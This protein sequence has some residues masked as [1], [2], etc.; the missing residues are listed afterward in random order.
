LAGPADGQHCNNSQQHTATKPP[1]G[2]STT[3]G[4]LRTYDE[5]ARCGVPMKRARKASGP[6]C[7]VHTYSREA[8]R[9][10]RGRTGPWRAAPRRP[11]TRR[12]RAAEGR[13]FRGHFLLLC[14]G[15]HH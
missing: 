13:G 10:G 11:R 3:G 9:A 1:P 14:C 8:V 4:T 12:A 2:R 5:Y 7:I 15:T 6:A